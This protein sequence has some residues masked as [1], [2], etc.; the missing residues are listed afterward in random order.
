MNNPIESLPPHSSLVGQ[1]TEII[2]TILY[3]TAGNSTVTLRSKKTGDRFT[4][5]FGRPKSSTRGDGARP[6]W[7][8]LLTGPDNS[9]DY[10]FFGTWFPTGDPYSWRYKHSDKSRIGLSAPGVIAA[11]WFMQHMWS[12]DPAAWARMFGQVEVWHEGQCGRCGRRLTVPE[13]VES[14]FGPECLSRVGGGQ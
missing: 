4:F 8:N 1:F 11:R 9:K 10:T 7:G 2:P 13:S 3:V 14:G 6:V 5:R 12:G